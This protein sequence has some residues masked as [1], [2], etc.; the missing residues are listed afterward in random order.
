MSNCRVKNYYRVFSTISNN[1]YLYNNR[2]SGVYNQFIRNVTDSVINGKYISASRYG[3]PQNSKVVG[4]QFNSSSF[5]NN[6]I[7]YFYDVFVLTSIASG[8]ISNNT[9]NRCV[10]V[11]HDAMG[12]MT[13]CN[14]LFTGINKDAI[15]LS[16]LTTDQQTALKAEEWCVIK[17]DDKANSY[18]NHIMAEVTFANNMGYGVDNYIYIGDSTK[19]IVAECEFRGNMI[20][21][22]SY[23]K[24]SAVDVGF[25]NGTST[26]TNYNSFQN[27]YFD[28]L[29]MKEWT[30]LPNPSLLGENAKS[31]KCFPY[32]KAIYNNEIYIN[33]NGT[34][35]MYAPPIYDGGIA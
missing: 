4:N 9:F 14:N 23:N 18:A 21:T 10:C 20:N 11:F 28:F 26:E 2:F 27:V 24:P 35:R 13:V 32:M 8:T 3:L 30:T 22:G 5:Q 34:W 19:V 16:V 6:L 15:D 29:D 33:I 25:R 31:V 7:D 1:S 17:F 12:H